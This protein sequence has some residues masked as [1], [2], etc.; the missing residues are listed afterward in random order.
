MSKGISNT[1]AHVLQSLDRRLK[2]HMGATDGKVSSTKRLGA[3]TRHGCPISQLKYSVYGEVRGF[4]GS[5]G[6]PLA[7]TRAR[8]LHCIFLT[9]DMQ[10]LPVSN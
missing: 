1:N 2:I 10:W 7:H 4:K 3:Y 6:T 8:E 5:C 9:I